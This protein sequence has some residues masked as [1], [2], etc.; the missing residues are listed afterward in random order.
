[1]LEFALQPSPPVPGLLIVNYLGLSEY[2]L[3]RLV[4][5]MVRLHAAFPH[6]QSH[7]LRLANLRQCW[8]KPEAINSVV[9]RC[10]VH[11]G[12]ASVQELLM[13]PDTTSSIVFLSC[14][15]I[16][17][18]M[19]WPLGAVRRTCRRGQTS[20]R[21]W[22]ISR[23]TI[24]PIRWSAST[25][26]GG[27]MPIVITTCFPPPRVS[28]MHCRLVTCRKLECSLRPVYSPHMHPLHRYD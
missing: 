12:C 20:R 18:M 6:L 21:A 13:W 23:V 27:A 2:L 11:G 3:I 7:L 16:F 4:V 10:F 22:H 9:R 8:K 28:P 15:A 25:P 17:P 1:M 26:S 19:T 14:A 24:C 5:R